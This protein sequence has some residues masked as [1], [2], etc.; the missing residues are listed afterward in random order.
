MKHY[1][2]AL[3]NSKAFNHRIRDRI[4][5][6]SVS[7][8]NAESDQEF[9]DIVTEFYKEFGVGKFGLNKAFHIIM[10]DE[11]KQVDIEPITRV[12]HIELSD[13]VGYELQ[14]AKLIENTEAFIEGARQTTACFSVTAVPVNHPVSKGDLKSVL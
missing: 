4:V 3:E 12:E 1:E 11:A 7:L 6:L 9:Q 10:D 5:E 8:E 2:N 13:L 14:K